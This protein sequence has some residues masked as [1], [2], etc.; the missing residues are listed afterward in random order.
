MSNVRVIE[1]AMASGG[2]VR[3]NRKGAYTIA[4]FLGLLIPGVVIFLLEFLSDKVKGRQD[5]QRITQAPILGEISH[6]DENDALVVKRTS[7]RFIAEQ[8]RIVRTNLQ[9][10][11]PKQDNI[12]LLVTSSTSGEG[13][14]FVS[15]NIGAVMALTGKRTAII[16]FDIRKPKVMS[17]LKLGKGTGITNFIIGKSEFEDL[18]VAVPGIDNLF[19]I[20]CGPI[21]PNPSEILLDVRIEELMS[22]VRKQFDVVIIDTA[23]VGL[24]SDAIV[25]GKYADASLYIVRHNFTYKKQLHMLDEIFIQ[26][27]LPRLSI[28]VNDIQIQGGQGRYY[29]YGGYGFS[30]Y[31]YGYGSDY[32]DKPAK[33]TGFFRSVIDWTRR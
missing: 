18:P 33:K 10:I 22:R 30:G 1:P 26:K 17:G 9:Y 28:V 8:F 14:S 21:P 4:L 27:R 5:I 25:L 24:V 29:G 16:E 19:V 32:F 23:P 11:L 12:V 2:P 20:P 31:G 13:K 7:R 3:P 15:T 6:S